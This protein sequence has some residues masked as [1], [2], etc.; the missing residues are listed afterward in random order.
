M[1]P[2]EKSIVK[3]LVAVAWADGSVEAPEAGVFEGLLFAFDAT[4]EEEAE[5]LEYAKTRRTLQDIPL[6]ALSADDRALLLG[7]AALLICADGV[8]TDAERTLL[9]DL[10]RLLEI[11]GPEADKIISGARAGAKRASQPP[12]SSGGSR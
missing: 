6:D 1:T 7:N 5:I 11:G 4:D 10:T 12:P 3:G 8:E 2:N 9:R